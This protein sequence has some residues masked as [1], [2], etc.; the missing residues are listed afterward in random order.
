MKIDI[1][2]K[3]DTLFINNKYESNYFFNKTL[4]EINNLKSLKNKKEFID[5]LSEL[6]Q[7]I[8]SINKNIDLCDKKNKGSLNYYENI[9]NFLKYNKKSQHKLNDFNIDKLFFLKTFINKFFTNKNNI[10]VS[11][12]EFL[13][14]S[15]LYDSEFVSNLTIKQYYNLYTKSLNIWKII[16]NNNKIDLSSLESKYYAKMFTIRLLIDQKMSEIK[17]VVDDFFEE[18]INA[19]KILSNLKIKELINL[20]KSDYINLISSFDYSYNELDEVILPFNCLKSDPF[21]EKLERIIKNKISIKNKFIKKENKF[22]KKFVETN[23]SNDQM[24][25]FHNQK[26]KNNIKIKDIPYNGQKI[27]VVYSYD[28]I[29]NPVDIL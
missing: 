10:N 8:I 29:E 18:D 14:N 4:N 23:R 7:K 19:L 22:Y 25:I 11:Q 20:N 9:I 15:K 17:Q 24:I 27:S 12:I 28:I 2:I 13:I 16:K 3:N 5:N 6:E 1:Y 21:K 26:G